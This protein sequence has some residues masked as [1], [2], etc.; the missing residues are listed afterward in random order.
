MLYYAAYF[1]FILKSLEID[2]RESKYLVFLWYLLINVVLIY[3]VGYIIWRFFNPLSSYRIAFYAIRIFIFI[4]TLVILVKCYQLRNI[5]FQRYIL[6]G[7][8]IYFVLSLLSISVD[9]N[10]SLKTTFIY[11]TEWLSIGTFIDILFFSVAVSYRN[12]KMI[13]NYN[14]V[15]LDDANKIIDMQNEVL[16]KQIALENERTRVAS[17]M[18]DDLGSG[19]TKIKFLSQGSREPEKVLENF[20]KIKII[21][22][23]LIENMGEII[24]ALRDENDSSENLFAF[25]KKYAAE[26][27]EDNNLE[28]QIFIDEN[29]DNQHVKGDVRKNIFLSVKEVLHNIVKH[30]E[31]KQV[32]INIVMQDFLKITIKDDGKGFDPK[33]TKEGNGLKNLKKRMEK[34]KGSM[35]IVQNNGTEIIFKIPFSDKN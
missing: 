31:A 15:L 4:F 11:P 26:Y 14:Q 17:D 35:E 3:V 32:T 20:D 33:S 28:L 18:H 23:E 6:Y 19:L 13:E 21:A 27:T 9:F 12:Q 34:L 2:E 16:E 30:S 24:W 10:Y 8:S 7:S 5:T 29:I 22:V 1:N 25:I